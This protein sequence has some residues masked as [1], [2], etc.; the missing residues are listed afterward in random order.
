MVFKKL[1]I[2]CYVMVLVTSEN[3]MR[4]NGRKS[5][6]IA[7]DNENSD[8]QVS[9][10][11]T[12]PF[13]SIPFKKTID[14]VFGGLPGLALPKV[15]INPSALA[16]GATM[17]LATSVLLPLFNKGLGSYDT[18]RYYRVL[19]S[20]NHETN[21]FSELSSQFL[22]V[23]RGC[24]LRIACWISQRSNNGESGGTVEQIIRNKLI[25]SIMNST[26]IEEAIRNGRKGYDCS[27]YEPCPIREEH[28][29]GL[30]KNFAILSNS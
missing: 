12:V 18:D 5:R 19:D 11:F 23:S 9:L 24:P 3:K 29:P 1:F 22:S 2:I 10:D 8:I 16:F 25:S 7:F 6:F 27:S 30:M 15:N 28:L 14:S 17:I 26:A 13:V 4:R 20:E 21:I